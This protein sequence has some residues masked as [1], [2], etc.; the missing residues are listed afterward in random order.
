MARKQQSSME[1]ITTYG[2]AI[3]AIVVALGVLYS[4]GIFSFGSGAPTGC[5]VIEGFSCTKPILYSSG[6]LTMQFGQI[7]TMKTI[8]ATGCSSNSTAP[9][10]SNWLATSQT[11]QSGQTVNLTFNCPGVQSSKQ[12]GA[13]YSGTLWLQYSSGTGGA[14]VTQQVAQINVPVSQYGNP[15]ASLLYVA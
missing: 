14:A 5:A 13:V 2:W 12:L 7:G 6:A 10:G 8:T 3:I 9:T 11:L 15:L 1:F 4:L